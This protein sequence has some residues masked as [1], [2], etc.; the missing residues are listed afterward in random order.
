MLT[1]LHVTV[2]FPPFNEINGARVCLMQTRLW[3][4]PRASRPLAISEEFH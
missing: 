3:L 1:G 2:F 4:S